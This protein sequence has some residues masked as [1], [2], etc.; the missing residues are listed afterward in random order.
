MPRAAQPAATRKPSSMRCVTVLDPTRSLEPLGNLTLGP[1]PN[2]LWQLFSGEIRSSIVCLNCGAL[3]CSHEPFLDLSLPVPR[4]KRA[5]RSQSAMPPIPGSPAVT[6]EEVLARLHTDLASPHAQ[7]RLGACL[8]AFGEHCP[9]LSRIASPRV[10]Y[11]SHSSDSPG[12]MPL[13]TLRGHE[14]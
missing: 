6:S 4:T 12:T 7:L 9:H 1:L 5:D 3:S 2:R 14:G 8:Q 13:A 11:G 10:L